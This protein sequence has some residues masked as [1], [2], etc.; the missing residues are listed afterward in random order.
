MQ[1][2]DCFWEIENIGKRTVQLNYTI[3]DTYTSE[4]VLKA[5][6]GYQYIV[7]KVPCGNIECLLGLQ[8][9]GFNVI[10]TQMSLSKK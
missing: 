1:V 8:N 9:D 2:Q 4:T 5:M 3:E 10:E 6:E 7:A